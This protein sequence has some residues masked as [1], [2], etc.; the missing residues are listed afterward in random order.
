MSAHTSCCITATAAPKKNDPEAAKNG[1]PSGC[2]VFHCP[3]PLRFFQVTDPAVKIVFH[4]FGKGPLR[5]SAEK[6]ILF[7]PSVAALFHEFLPVFRKHE[8][9]HFLHVRIRILSPRDD[10]QVHRQRI[11]TVV[12]ILQRRQDAVHG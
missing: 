2:A 11:G 1:A 7:Q 5:R 12:D 6:F 10:A 4:G 8:I 9:D 3:I